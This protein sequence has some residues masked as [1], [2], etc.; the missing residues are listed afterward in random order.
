[1]NGAGAT[2]PN[3]IYQKWFTEYSAAHP[4]V[5]INYQSLGS[6][7]G[8]RQ[9][10]A[11]TVD[12]GASD[13]PMTNE[14]LSKCPVRILHIPT[15]L[16]AVVPSYNVPGVRQELKFTPEL[17]AGIFLGKIDNWDD[18]AIAEVN[19][20]VKFPDLPIVVFHRSDASGSTYVLTDYLSKV[21]PE[22]NSKVGKNTS[23]QWPVGPGAKGNEGVTG[24]I[25]H[26]DGAIG[27][28]ELNYAVQNNL[29]Y[30]LVRNQNGN[31]VKA[32]LDSTTA[33]AAATVAKIPPD[34]RV[35]ITDPQGKYA[36]PIAS[37]TWLLIPQQSR[38]ASKGAVLHNFLI[39]MLGDG[40]REAAALTYAPLPK[41]MIQPLQVTIN[42]VH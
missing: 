13:S 42:T 20:G 27:Y 1:L 33:A 34:Y 21:S 10:I 38:D 39:W 18:P 2:F 31:F 15:V 24:E 35:S 7:A 19:P 4:G 23:V 28:I 32:S 25:R 36:Y 6:G 37:F 40:Q 12:F 9:L 14:Q 22:W 26:I 29:S 17:L 3:P 5:Q 16:G 41:E 8:I 30:G 11:G